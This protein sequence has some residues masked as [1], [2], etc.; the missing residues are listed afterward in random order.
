M[1]STALVEDLSNRIMART[2]VLKLAVELN[3]RV[4]NGRALTYPLPVT[5]LQSPV[6]GQE[7]LRGSF[8]RGILQLRGAPG[9][10]ATYRQNRPVKILL[11]LLDTSH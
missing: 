9:L 11:G 5:N 6:T 7:P 1:R 4:R 3:P 10:P 8:H 2:S